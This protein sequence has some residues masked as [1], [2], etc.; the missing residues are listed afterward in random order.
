MIDLNYFM[1]DLP[2]CPH[3]DEDFDIWSNDYFE[4]NLSDEATDEATCESCHKEFV[5]KNHLT[6]SFSTATSV[7]DLHNGVYGPQQSK[8]EV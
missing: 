6:Y 8:G 1:N 2:K 3:C 7:C 4:Y 5:F